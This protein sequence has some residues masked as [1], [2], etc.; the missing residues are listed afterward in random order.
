M[1]MTTRA[2]LRGGALAALVLLL[3]CQSSDPSA[4]ATEAGAARPAR[5]VGAGDGDADAFGKE[6]KNLVT[7]IGGFEQWPN[8]DTAPPDGWRIVEGETETQIGRATGKDEIHGGKSALRIM[9]ES[10]VVSVTSGGTT[11]SDESNT[12]LRGRPMT[13]GVWAKASEP[14][15]AFINIRDGVTQSNVVDHPGDGEWHFITV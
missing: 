14:A 8:G 13:A 6:A 2:F 3:G 4:P 1:A 9:A 5:T 11:I 7:S 15:A 12:V 10:H